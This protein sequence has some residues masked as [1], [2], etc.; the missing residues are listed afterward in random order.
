MD[1]HLPLEGRRVARVTF[2]DVV[3][4]LTLELPGWTTDDPADVADYVLQ[5]SGQ[6]HLTEA[7]VASTTDPSEGP[8]PLCL[9][10][11]SKVVAAAVAQPDGSLRVEFA[12]GS[13]LTVDPDVYE[14]WELS[15][16]NGL[17]VVSIAG[18]GLDLWGLP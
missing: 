7:D 16:S 8:D 14:P 12:D 15:S 4:H 2:S 10:M 5:I 9:R 3:P 6:L 18:G 17:Q 1:T 11:L 13:A